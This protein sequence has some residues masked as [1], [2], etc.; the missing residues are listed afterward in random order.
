M[1]KCFLILL[2]FVLINCSSTKKTGN[3]PKNSKFEIVETFLVD[4]KTNVNFSIYELRFYKI[5]SALD[6]VALMYQNYGMW[7]KKIEGK[8]Q[9]NINRI[10]WDNIKLIE[11]YDEEFTI[12]ADGTET[13]NNYFA[14]L[15]VFDSKG[16]NC[17][18]NK[19]PLKEKLTDLFVNK[20]KRIE[21]SQSVSDFI[22]SN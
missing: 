1:K 4:E 22:R 13:V 8:H 3:K 18:N 7:D 15:M 6:G 2:S 5:M 21:R 10:I 9:Q 17:F 20:M 11:G 12:V 14:C 16:K 19:H